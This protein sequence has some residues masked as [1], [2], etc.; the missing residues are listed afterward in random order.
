MKGHHALQQTL[1][2]EIRDQG[3]GLPKGFEDRIF[4][5]FQQGGSSPGGT[6]LGLSIP[7]RLV[8][9]MGGVVGVQSRPKEGATFWMELPAG[10]QPGRL[11]TDM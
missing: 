2:L 3:E 10:L 8:I 5:K 1:R 11:P 4:G 7:R 6:G 9:A